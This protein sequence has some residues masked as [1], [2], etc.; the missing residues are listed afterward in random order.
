MDYG[1]VLQSDSQDE[2]SVL[3]A[4]MADT[5]QAEHDVETELSDQH[6]SQPHEQVETVEPEKPQVDWDSEENPYV[7]RFKQLQ[8][9][10]QKEIEDKRAYEHRLQQIEQE[11]EYQQVQQHTQNMHPQDRAAYLHQWQQHQQIKA[12]EQQLQ[13]HSQRLEM[14]ARQTVMRDIAIKHGVPVTE[15]QRFKDPDSMEYHAEAI[16]RERRERN[17]LARQAQGSDRFEG[18]AP[19]RAHTNNKI[20]GQESW[21]EIQARFVAEAERMAERNR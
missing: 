18:D 20:T 3:A 9:R 8:A 12:R 10:V 16:A 1:S 21:A 5:Q 17:K 13:E 15:I 11:R 19:G 4:A 7:T 2:G 6:E 14:A